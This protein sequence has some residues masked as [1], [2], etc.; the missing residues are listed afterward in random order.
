MTRH[1]RK[2]SRCLALLAPVLLSG[3]WGCLSEQEAALADVPSELGAQHGT[4]LKEAA[5]GDDVVHTPIKAIPVLASFESLM[6]KYKNYDMNADGRVEI[7]ELKHLF[8]NP[9][10]YAPAENGAIVV[11]VDPRLVSDDPSNEISRFEMQLWL[12]MYAVD[13]RNEGYFPWFVE[14]SV[15]DGIEHQDGRTLLAMR[16]FLQDVRKY[17]PLKGTILI[18]SFPE[19]GIVRSTLLKRRANDPM[20]FSG[21]T[22]LTVDDV[23]YL[24]LDAEF[25]TPR[26]EIVLADLDGNWEQL[27]R[28]EPFN[29]QGAQVLPQK[30]STVSWLPPM[31]PVFPT[32]NQTLTTPHFNSFIRSFEDVFLV[33]DET[34]SVSMAN[35]NLTLQIVSTEEPSPEATTLDK[36][37]PNRIA[38][39]EILVSRI[40]ARHVAVMPTSAPDLDGKLPLGADGKP[41]A[42]RFSRATNVQWL[43]DPSFERRLITEYIARSRGFRNGNDRQKPFRVSA[44]RGAVELESPQS[45]VNQ[46][47][48]ANSGFGAPVT[49][50][51]ANLIDYVRWLKTPAT[52][53]GIAAHSSE[54]ISQFPGLTNTTA[55][56]QEIGRAWNWK[57][58]QVGNEYRLEPTL[59]S[60]TDAGAFL[61]RTLY[62]NKWLADSGQTFI[63]HNGCDVNKPANYRDVPYNHED[64][65]GQS[66]H[67]GNVQN[68]E[69]IL[70]FANA[71]AIMGRNKVF[72]D[73]PSGFAEEVARTGRFGAGWSAYFY[74]EA[75]ND[76]LDEGDVGYGDQ[77]NQRTLAR[78]RSYYWNLLG[79]FTLQLKY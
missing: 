22:S 55:L 7:N 47:K 18:G 26:G 17:Y 13:L 49:A 54:T 12:G 70:F 63:V 36:A 2:R 5:I 78:K 14:A 62:E 64:Y 71:L 60:N 51:Q 27:Y 24:N 44:I 6:A 28:E 45:M 43:R 48:K 21:G 58:T 15:Y 52:L 76:G 65:G 39:P 40:D 25:V 42:L 4:L 35:G 75:A 59:P 66:G 74:A 33:R 53:R 29:F 16:R 32:D 79:D 38:R 23:S 1:T 46:L 3:A 31:Y 73:S 72:Y 8:P 50:D 61:Y 19:A 41:Q 37:Q 56:E 69:S 30:V 67:G 10:A 34:A 9:E 20:T 11:F 57:R 77:R 68:A